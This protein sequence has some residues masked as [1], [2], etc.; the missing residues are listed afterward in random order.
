MISKRGS[1]F[2]GFS[3]GIIKPMGRAVMD[4]FI[5]VECFDFIKPQSECCV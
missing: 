1:E 5:L 4:L 3:V 2:K